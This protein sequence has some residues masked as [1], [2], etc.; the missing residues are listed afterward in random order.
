MNR[1]AIAIA[2]LGA[3]FVAGCTP[4]QTAKAN[5]SAS[6]ASAGVKTADVTK[7]KNDYN[8]TVNYELGMHCTGFD[9]TYCCVLPPYNSVQSQVIKTAD[10]PKAYPE[11]LESDE[12]DHSVLV[13][14]KKRFK[15]AYG[16]IDNTYSEGSKLAYWNVPYDVDGDGKWEKNENVAN[17]YWTHLYVYKD[18][19][20]SNPK[21]TSKD[22]EKKFVGL[23]I[24]VPLDN[25]P[26]GA[27]VPSPMKGGHL[28]YTG[29]KGTIVFTKSPV[30][31]NVPIVLTNPGIWD[32]LGL[33]LTPFT[34]T[35]AAKNP[36]TLVESDIQ[37]YLCQLP[38]QRDGERRQVH[39]VQAGEGLLEGAGGFG[40]D[41]QPE[42]DLHL[43]HGD[44]RRPQRHRLPE[45][46]Q[47]EQ[48]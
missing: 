14:G 47:A 41:R 33:P 35:V 15:L 45:E 13:D 44:P 43:H 32:A 28:H 42:G 40:L 22:S 11:L 7:P 1:K 9:F 3:A 20:G 10:G 16:H 23:N 39:S 46:L 18:L 27:A 37:P 17:A 5:A 38:R 30:L 4:Q 29:E 6:G 25:G 21:N 24:P 19:K 48:P 26:A 2:V 12:E 31:D 34:D 8:I 36:L